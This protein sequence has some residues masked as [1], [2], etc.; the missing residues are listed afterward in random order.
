MLAEEAVRT[1]ASTGLWTKNNGKALADAQSG[2]ALQLKDKGKELADAEG[3]LASLS[4][5]R[6]VQ[7][8]PLPLF[9]DRRTPFDPPR[10]PV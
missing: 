8:V 10:N 3:R 5:S 7:L 6:D 1:S 9:R 2:L 4:S